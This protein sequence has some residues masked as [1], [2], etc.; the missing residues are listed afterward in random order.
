MSD[1][2][3]VA[4]RAGCGSAMLA[5]LGVG[6]FAHNV[7]LEGDEMALGFG[8]RRRCLD[9]VCNRCTVEREDD[10]RA[11]GVEEQA[12]EDEVGRNRESE[13]ERLAAAA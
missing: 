1:R 13:L 11:E 7:S 5:D 4:K 10:A 12:A 6:T 8:R 2:V 9:R 3:P